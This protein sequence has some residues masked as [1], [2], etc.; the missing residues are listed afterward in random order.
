M[1]LPASNGNE[2]GH[3]ADER[4]FAGAVGAKQAEDLAL[5]HAEA[6]V[7]DG[8][9]IAIALDDVFHRN[10]SRRAAP[11]PLAAELCVCRAHC[12]TSLLLG[13]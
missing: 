10:G 1:A 4:A 2:R 5:S 7:L 8:F 12:F 6:D 13:M 9:K 11:L 3:H